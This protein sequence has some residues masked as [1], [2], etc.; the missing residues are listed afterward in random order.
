MEVNV[1]KFNSIREYPGGFP[2]AEMF[3]MQ[4]LQQCLYVLICVKLTVLEIFDFENESNAASF[5]STKSQNLQK[6]FYLFI[7]NH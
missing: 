5:F 3:A 6:R 7:I 2:Y 4:F 1:L